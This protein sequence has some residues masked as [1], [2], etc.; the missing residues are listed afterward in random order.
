MAHAQCML[1]NQ[2]YKHTLGI[3]NTYCS[4]IAK[5]VA[6]MRPKVTFTYIVCLDSLPLI[7]SSP[8]LLRSALISFA[9]T[10]NILC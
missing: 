7:E 8:N 1:D 2:G 6:R 3:C 4:P 9:P 5:M 10:G